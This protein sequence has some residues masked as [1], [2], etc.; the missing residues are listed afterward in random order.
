MRTIATVTLDERRRALVMTR[1][2]TL[3]LLT[4]VTV[5]P[6]TSRVRR[7]AATVRSGA[8]GQ[9]CGLLFDDQEPELARAVA[10]ASDLFVS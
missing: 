6:I 5:A 8:V 7:L 2:S 3:Y 4:W 1:R 9:T 10:D